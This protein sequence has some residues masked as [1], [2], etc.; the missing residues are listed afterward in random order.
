[1]NN[2]LKPPRKAL[3]F[4]RWFCRNDY[5]EEIEGNL[6]ELYEQQY[7]E[8]SA[9]ARRQFTWNVLR[10]FRPAF[11][12]SFKI[13]QPA[14]H[15]AMLRHNLVL[16]FRNF[17]RYKGSFLINLIGLA[18]GLACA[19]LIY[20]WVQDELRVD[21]FHTNERQLFQVMENHHMT[22]EILT[23]DGTPDLL[24]RALVEEIPEVVLAT[25]VTPSAWFGNFTLAPN[26]DRPLKAVGQ[27]ADK[28]FFRVF[29][30]EL[31]QGQAQQVL[32]DK[33]SMVIS[34]ALALR[35]FNTTE[36]IVGK[37][38]EWQLLNMTN[39]VVITGVFSGTPPHS[40]AQF[41]FVL[42][43]EAWLT[44][45][46]A[47]GRSI[48][49]DNHGPLTYLVLQAG[50]NVQ[51]FNAKVEPYIQE[52]VDGSNITLF[53]T[54]YADQYLYGKYE[55]GVQAGGRIVYVRLFALI[56]IFILLIACI[57][58]MNLATARASR[59]LKEVGV[60]KAIGAS[61]KLLIFQFVGESVVMVGLSLLLSLI[62]VI[63]LLPEFNQ[64]TGKQL[65]LTIDV[66]LLSLILGI[67]WATGLLAGSYPAFY[68]SGFNPVMVLK[69]RLHT[70]AGEVWTRK[71]LVV[72]QFALS[73]MLIVS[74]LVVYQQID[75]LQTKNL[76]YNK[77]N[78]IYFDREGKV[79]ES[80][81][82]FFAEVKK[83]PG[84]THISSIN[85][86]LIGSSSGTYGVGWEGKNP[87]EDI[88][89]EE[90]S[91]NYDMLETLE[92]DM[93]AGRSFSRAFGSE[94]TKVIFNETAIKVMGLQD[95]IGKT[96]Q[97]YEGEMEIIGVVKDFH[98]ESL[99]EYVKPLFFK[100]R[101]DETLKI[102]A[103]IEAGKEREA[104]VSLEKL[105]QE[106]N[107]GF[108]F[109]YQFLDTT[110]QAQ[111]EAEQRVATLSRYFA[112]LAILISCLGLFGL[113]AFTAE[114]RL[115]EIGI[116]K[117]LGASAIS[118]VHLLSSDFTKMVLIAVAIAL[119]VSY[120]AAQRWLQNFAFSIPLQW[121]YF[122]GAGLIALLI[123]W[124]TVGLQTVKAARVNPVECLK[125]E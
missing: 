93:L 37:T 54:P 4:L 32:L 125:D 3:R 118:I 91:V 99:H 52:K 100:L 29:S 123:A 22:E 107:P 113:A 103:R 112:G 105:Y 71:G 122:V 12:R 41:D 43:Y 46:E 23:Y 116:R 76:G 2:Q 95:P 35:L 48:H 63:L 77:D 119:P 33:H 75:Y 24:A 18:S 36:N 117:A 94:E 6:L 86:N 28:D 97:H 66:S 5:L 14:N 106:F 90:V 98:F 19:L 51:E 7:K 74:V 42:S 1:M 30:Y 40:T 96:I 59:R 9:K 65:N 82:T 114:R 17:Q 55:N 39:Q 10:H 62:L 101:P 73:V 49:W 53:A 16:T 121:W 109:D 70:L 102:M 78:I 87:E 104:I 61:R 88:H 79:A 60:K 44:L 67:A 27:F 34:E 120:F 111:Y 47:I 50:T 8:S 15:R 108:T 115:K 38:L 21:K 81:E 80:Q 68:L 72:F 26:A 31:V 69:G 11:I 13:Y 85:E 45:S 56:A 110:Y 84:I 58:F 92:V 83:I 124:L 64:I 89:F 20:L 25:S 57:N